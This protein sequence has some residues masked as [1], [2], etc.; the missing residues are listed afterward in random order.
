MVGVE[1]FE[2]PTPW[3]QTKC[4]TRLRYT[5]TLDNV[6]YYLSNFAKGVKVINIIIKLDRNAIIGYNFIAEHIQT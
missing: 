5:P 1:R 4:A 2:L 6:L 3:T